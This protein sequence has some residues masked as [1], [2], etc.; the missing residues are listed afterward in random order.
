MYLLQVNFE[1][2]RMIAREVKNC[3]QY[4]LTPIMVSEYVLH[5][6]CAIYRIQVNSDCSNR[7]FYTFYSLHNI[8][9]MLITV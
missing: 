8:I 4:Y 7:K 5:L 1:K 3:K 2:L 9:I 6:K